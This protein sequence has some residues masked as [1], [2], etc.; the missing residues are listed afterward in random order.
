MGKIWKS[1]ETSTTN[2]FEDKFRITLD[3][4]INWDGSTVAD[5]DGDGDKTTGYVQVIKFTPATT[6][7]AS[8][9]RATRTTTA[10]RRARSR[11]K[12]P[13]SVTSVDGGEMGGGC[14]PYSTHPAA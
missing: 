11:S 9:S 6:R 5:P 4:A 1:E 8:A 7:S 12:C 13:D 2:S 10:T 14:A 3:K